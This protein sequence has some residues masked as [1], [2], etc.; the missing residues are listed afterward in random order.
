MKR[1]MTERGFSI[2]ESRDLYNN[3][4]SIQK[5]SL[6]DEDAIWFGINNADP[7]IMARLV[8]ENGSGWVKYPVPDDVMFT[9][10][11]HLSRQQ[12]AELIPILQQFVDTGDI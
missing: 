10:R 7:K 9:T 8:M 4:F 6:A 2:I 11:M 3:E 5:S 12:V 1:R